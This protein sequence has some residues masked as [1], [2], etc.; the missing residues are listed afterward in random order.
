MNVGSVIKRVAE[1]DKAVLC[2]ICKTW[3]HQGCGGITEDLYKAI[4]RFGQCG[5]KEIPWHCK[6]SCYGVRT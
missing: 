4:E 3:F 5:T 6:I 2:D 1:S